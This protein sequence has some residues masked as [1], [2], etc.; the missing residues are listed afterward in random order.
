M[1]ENESFNFL[2]FR[3]KQNKFTRS[4]MSSARGKLVYE[5]PIIALYSFRNEFWLCSF[6]YS[7][8]SPVVLVIVYV[9]LPLYCAGLLL[10]IILTYM[11]FSRLLLLTVIC[12]LR[13]GLNPERCIQMFP[14]IKVFWQIFSLEKIAK[15]SL[16]MTSKVIKTLQRSLSFQTSKCRI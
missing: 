15:F 13:Q 9:A 10:F 6:L 11:P 12:L 16:R 5:C 14:L 8:Y 3:S 4:W 7:V 1:D 2:P